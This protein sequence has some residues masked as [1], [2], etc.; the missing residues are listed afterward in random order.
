MALCSKGERCCE[1]AGCSGGCVLN[2]RSFS[3]RIIQDEGCPA[4]SLASAAEAQRRR[5]QKRAGL[6]GPGRAA[7]GPPLP[8]APSR[9]LS[10][11]LRLQ[12]WAAETRGQRKPEEGGTG[13]GRLGYDS[14]RPPPRT[15]PGSGEGCRAAFSPRRPPARALSAALGPDPWRLSRPPP[16]C[17]GAP[18]ARP[19]AP[20]GGCGHPQVRRR[21]CYAESEDVG[22]PGPR[23]S[24]AGAQ[25]IP[26]LSGWADT[27]RA[28]SQE[29]QHEGRAREKQRVA[30]GR[31][32]DP[33]SPSLPVLG[34]YLL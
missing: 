33:A 19:L 18:P 7:L 28:P 5:P 13:Q 14:A 3:T 15:W 23:S 10:L 12:H 24:E 2:C 1:G 20:D 34:F 17:G 6:R 25:P 27:S 32:E 4:S 31:G 29:N 11:P 16:S 30:S 21:R 8:L 22:L 26:Y 9:L